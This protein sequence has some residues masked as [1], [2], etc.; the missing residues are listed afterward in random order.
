MIKLIKIHR[1]LE[2]FQDEYEFLSKDVRKYVTNPLNAYKLIKLAYN[3]V[4]LL[5]TINP[6]KFDSFYQNFSELLPKNEDL[7][8]SVE[9]I[10]R[11]HEVYRFKCEDF[12]EGIIDGEQTRDPLTAYDLYVI[13][14]V[15]IELKDKYHFARKYLRLSLKRL[16]NE[17]FHPQELGAVNIRYDLTVAYNNAGKYK[18]ALSQAKKVMRMSKKFLTQARKIQ[19][20]ALHLLQ[21]GFKAKKIRNPFSDKYKRDGKFADH[22]EMIL[23]SQVCRGNITITQKQIV[24]LKC[25]Y[26]SNTPYTRLVKSKIEEFY[27]DPYIIVFH[28]VISD[29]EVEVMKKVGKPYH[30]RGRVE[31]DK[32][33]EN[34]VITNDRVSQISWLEHLEPSFEEK[35]N[36]RISAMTGLSMKYS[37]P[38]Q[39][40]NYG[41]G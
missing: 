31:D 35:L 15:A 6:T 29:N 30:H 2:E 5:H 18:K 14:S 36:K 7:L 24:Q 10:F 32:G 11:L 38:Y 4:A 13:G 41:I 37:E 40:Q 12:A 22:K 28:D 25:R 39:I 33:S 21:I 34:G 3:D 27:L 16:G 9:G 23:F 17:K 26:L 8:G 20:D 1:K 19:N